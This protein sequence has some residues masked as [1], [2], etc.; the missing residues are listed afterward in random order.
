MSE[1]SS[2]LSDLLVPAAARSGQRTPARAD[3]RRLAGRLLLAANDVFTIVLASVVVAAVASAVLPPGRVGASAGPVAWA[4]SAVMV[5]IANGSLGLYEATGR[6]AVERF[7]LRVWSA[8]VQPFLVV[9]VLALLGRTDGRALVTLMVAGCVW[10]PLSLLAETL[11]VRWLVARSAWGTRALLIGDAASTVPLA[12]FLLA[13]PEIG[14]QPV[15]LCGAA[16]TEQAPV[17]HLG[18]LAQARSLSNV[19]EIAIVTLSAGA[20]SLD[21][22]GLPFRR[23]LVVPEITGLPSLWLR[24]RAL[25][26]GPALEFS[27]PLQALP[28]LRA[29][30]LFDLCLAVPLL[31][32]AA[33]LIGLMALAICIV[34]PGPVFY[35]QR[36]VG[37]NGKPLQMLK[38]RTMHIDAEARLQDLLQNDPAAQ[39]EWTRCV[40][41][42]HDPRVLP[43]IGAF[44]RKLSLDELPQL[45][46][47]VRGDMSMVGPRPFPG[48]HLDRFDAEFQVLR[49]SVRPGL[50]GLWQVSERSDADLRQQQMLDTFYIR[51]WSLWF[52]LYVA[53]LTVPAVLAPRGAR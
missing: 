49:T 42:T 6:S 23:V 2:T 21:L 33:P 8:L 15:G 51:N 7:R 45:W 1:T 50:T 53:L 52:D 13:H 16:G 25:G 43:V 20:A 46:N 18:S 17:A 31:L 11:V 12:T 47:V 4:A 30:R 44:M 27:N 38:M 28:N 29:K 22:A 10:L 37:W 40:K 32:L 19:A 35:M 9:A 34:S 3:A 26:G 24:P 14:L 36:R 41:L 39:A 5:L 48:Y